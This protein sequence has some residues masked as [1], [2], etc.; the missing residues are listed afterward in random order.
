MKNPLRFVTA[1]A[2]AAGSAILPGMA[3][4]EQDITAEAAAPCPPLPA[5]DSSIQQDP[6]NS[7]ALVSRGEAYSD[8]GAFACAIAD[9]T[10]ALALTPPDSDDGAAILTRRS[11][12]YAAKG[13]LDLAIA[14][15][16]AVIQL[17]PYDAAPLYTR[18]TLRAKKSD[19][20]EAIDDYSDAVARDPQNARA[21]LGRGEAYAK[22]N[23][24]QHAT[25]DFNQALKLDPKLAAA[26]QDLGLI[27]QAGGD[28]GQAISYFNQAIAI[29]PRL[30]AARVNRGKV[31]LATGQFD[32]AIEDYTQ[33]LDI[34]AHSAP[35]FAGRAVAYRARGDLARA[36]A[37]LGQATALDPGDADNFFNLGLVNYFTGKYSDALR[38]FA[39][40]T[41]LTA[42]ANAKFY[43][44]FWAWL[45]KAKLGFNGLTVFSRVMTGMDS[46]NWPAPIAAL[47]QGSLA[48]ADLP[49][50]AAQEDQRC[51]AW[52]YQGEWYLQHNRQDLAMAAFKAAIATGDFH[53][54]EYDAARF[55]L[56]RLGEKLD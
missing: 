16:S 2:F 36:A 28:S 50:A 20:A 32:L 8:K 21:F 53:R 7:K 19:F 52:F 5:W 3:K 46:S 33:A 54:A 18:G 43:P 13:D 40:S 23:D 4:A 42:D 48:P 37:D 41:E 9:F 24:D 55:E 29:D 22:L 47:Y 39:R 12:A 45:A 49:A 44:A 31:F 27:Y 51:E 38:A 11:A 10:A 25:D 1:I 17:T 56:G 30:L 14:D 6:Q 34:D 35:S 15:I 26:Y